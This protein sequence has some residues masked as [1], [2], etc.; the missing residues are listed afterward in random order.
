MAAH[1]DICF[2]SCSS[3]V[4]YLTLE[5]AFKSEGGNMKCIC[6]FHVLSNS[7][8]PHKLIYAMQGGEARTLHDFCFRG[9]SKRRSDF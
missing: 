1:F 7:V 6:L 8:V 9:E 3:A 2:G 4:K 5:S